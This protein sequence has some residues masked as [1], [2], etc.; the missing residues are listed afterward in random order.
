MGYIS[1]LFKI[2]LQFLTNSK[3]ITQDNWA[4]AFRSQWSIRAIPTVQPLL[5][6]E[7]EPIAWESLDILEKLGCLFEL[8]EW[9]LEKPERLRRLVESEEETIS[10]VR[11]ASSNT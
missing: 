11:M 4:D 2:L 9:Q 7:E 1:W 10:W 5:G 6:T 3:T 8:C